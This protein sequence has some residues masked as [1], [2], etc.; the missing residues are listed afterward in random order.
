MTMAQGESD[1]TMC[2]ACNALQ[3]GGREHAALM[4]KGR[5]GLQTSAR[6]RM[7]GGEYFVCR[8]CGAEWLR[9]NGMHPVPRKKTVWPRTQPR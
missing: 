3:H 8:L 5:R 4:S 7:S 1:M 9:D 6:A 2:S